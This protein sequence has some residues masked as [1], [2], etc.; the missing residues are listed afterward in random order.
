MPNFFDKK[1]IF[2]ASKLSARG[3]F[4]FCVWS[5]CMTFSHNFKNKTQ[6]FQNQS[7][8]TIALKRRTNRSIFCSY[9]FEITVSDVPYV[10][11]TI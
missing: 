3:Q 2:V 11:L 10:I 4:I 1:F 6:N 8:D 5:M 7:C 9:E